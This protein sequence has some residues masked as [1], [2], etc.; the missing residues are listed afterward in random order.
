[1]TARFE[2]ARLLAALIVP[3]TGICG[4]LLVSALRRGI[5][6][7]WQIA[8]AGRACWP[9]RASAA[10]PS[11]AATKPA[12]T[13]ISSTIA[14]S[15]S[16]PIATLIATTKV[17][18]GAVV[19]RRTTAI[20]AR[21]IFLRRVVV[22]AEILRRR[23]VRFRLALFG[24][25]VSVG[26]LDRLGIVMLFVCRSMFF[27]RGFLTVFLVVMHLVVVRVVQ[28]CVTLEIVM[29]FVAVLHSVFGAV[30]ERF[31][32]QHFG[33]HGNRNRRGCRSVRLG[34]PMAVI[35]ILKIFEN[36]ADIQEGIAIETN[37][38]E[39]GLHARKHSGYAAFV[40]ATDKREL[41]FALD[42]DFD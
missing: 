20:R 6:R 34:M 2:S 30:A 12:A 4:T 11:T 38:H 35:V 8:T 21:R 9:G 14:A 15:V 41:F 32:R 31:A 13:P 26:M 17:L 5:F 19:A 33:V 36:I 42:V 39:S 24:F 3:A 7:R 29:S 23:G 40:D 16:T 25:R 37:V 18:A 10:T 1:M 22:M 28:R 27:E